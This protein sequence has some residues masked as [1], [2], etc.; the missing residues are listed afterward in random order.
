MKDNIQTLTYQPGMVLDFDSPEIATVDL[1]GNVSFASV[2][3][4]A[5]KQKMVRLVAD[6]STRNL[7]FPGWKFLSDTAPVSIAAGKTALISLYCFGKN[8]SDILATYSVQP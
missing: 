5:G 4:E 8:D 7:S 3:A 2:N 6:S 1:S